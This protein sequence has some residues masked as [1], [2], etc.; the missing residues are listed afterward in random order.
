MN[1]KIDGMTPA[2][3]WKGKL[4]DI[5]KKLTLDGELID[6]LSDN[7]RSCISKNEKSKLKSVK[8]F[9]DRGDEKGKWLKQNLSSIKISCFNNS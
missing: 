3:F 2:K 8:K 4:D 1:D 9:N 6:L 7:Y 5:I